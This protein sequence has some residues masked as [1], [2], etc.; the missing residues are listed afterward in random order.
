MTSDGSNVSGLV[1]GPTERGYFRP[2]IEGLRAVAV[3]GVLLF[4]AGLPGSPDSTAIW[5]P[6]G[7]IGGAGPHA[8]SAGV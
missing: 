1:G 8:A 5:A 7:M 3:L 4:H 2:D 6:T